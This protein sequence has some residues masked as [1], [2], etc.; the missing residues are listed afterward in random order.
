VPLRSSLYD[1]LAAMLTAGT[2]RVQVTDD[3]GRSVGN[4]T[5]EAVFSSSA[6]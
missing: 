4:L 1:A 3:N 6:S 5:R 2:D